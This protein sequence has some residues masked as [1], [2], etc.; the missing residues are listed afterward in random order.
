MIVQRI[1]EIAIEITIERHLLGNGFASVA[2]ENPLDH[3]FWCRSMTVVIFIAE[4][5][6]GHPSG[7]AL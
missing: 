1:A 3:S 5:H 6:L 7:C 4:P 2:T